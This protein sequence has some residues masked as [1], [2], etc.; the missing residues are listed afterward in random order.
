MRMPSLLLSLG[1]LL[2][3]DVA[4]A[5][6]QA[7]YLGKWKMNVAK[8]DF[9]ESTITYEQTPAKE[10]K[11]TADGESRTFK[12]DGKDYPSFDGRT[13]AWKQVDE[14]TWQSTHKLEGKTLWMRTTQLSQ[15][16]K[17]LRVDL[18]GTNPDGTPISDTT[19][20][21][22]V[23]G[24]PGLA[25]KW[26]TKNVQMTAGEIELTPQG[27]DGIVWS[28]PSRGSTTTA[29]FDGKDYPS[30]GKTY[31]PGFTLALKKA[32]PAGFESTVKYQGQ[33][34]YVARWAV[35]AD[36]KT[37]TETGEAVQAGEKY[38]VVYER[39]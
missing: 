28:D 14:R 15:D 6:E 19:T 33:P 1:L 16:G 25:G 36:G 34:L 11:V 3:C 31:G 20:Y 30:T 12:M 37:L 5:A 38:K 18:K 4:P 26:K 10:F 13:V 17:T 9:G 21:Q 2:A 35:S 32:G 39:Q 27:T 23:S 22:R 7:T 29:R 24:G 8:S